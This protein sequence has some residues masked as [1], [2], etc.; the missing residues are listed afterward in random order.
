MMHYQSYKILLKCN[1]WDFRPRK[2]A[3]PMYF[4]PY[5][6]PIFIP[7]SIPIEPKQTLVAFPKQLFQSLFSFFKQNIFK[8]RIYQPHHVSPICNSNTFPI[9]ILFQTCKQF[10]FQYT[11]SFHKQNHFFKTHPIYKPFQNMHYAQ[12]SSTYL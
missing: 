8:H 2:N 12:K 11:Q 6:S 1:N 3:Q 10:I 9:R 5:C 7:Y 4:E